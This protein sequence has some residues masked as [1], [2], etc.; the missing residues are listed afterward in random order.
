MMP[1][2]LLAAAGRMRGLLAWSPSPVIR[3]SLG[4]HAGGLAAMAAAPGCWPEALSLLAANH[5]ALAGCMHP[6][7]GRLGPTLTRLPGAEPRVALTFD[8]GPDPAVTP[9]VLDLL[10]AAGAKASFFV[11]GE[12]AAR[13][14]ALV[15][16]M[17]RRGHSVENHTYRH[18]LG[19]AAWGPGAMLQEIEAAQAAIAD[20][21]GQAPRFFRPPAGLRSPL[22]DPVL[23]LAGLS[24]ATWT[25][26]GYD[27]VCPRPDRVL[28]RLSRGLGRGDVL[29]LH[30]GR[31]ARSYAGTSVALDVLPGLLAR[32][33]GAGLSAVALP[34]AEDA[35][36]VAAATAGP[37]GAAA[38]RAPAAY[39]SR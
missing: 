24:L 1:P 6:R 33:A 7:C 23:A 21:C 20:S 18:P 19:F 26:R 34:P 13:H 11:I 14:P 32:I 15:R 28:A 8:D 36:R 39:A 22:L 12:R 17:L 5:V 3:A 2:A 35:P 16:E 4:L 27:A 30:D 29:L 38:S 10:D 37:A 25:R 31:S 9:R